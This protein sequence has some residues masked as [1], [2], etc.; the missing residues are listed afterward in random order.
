MSVITLRGQERHAAFVRAVEMLSEGRSH[1]W[2]MRGDQGPG[3]SVSPGDFTV[4][5][6]VVRHR[7][8]VC[9]TS[10]IWVLGIRSGQL[11]SRLMARRGAGQEELGGP[12]RRVRFPLRDATKRAGSTCNPSPRL[13]IL[14]WRG[15]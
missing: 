8:G 10:S 9:P 6:P 13:H 14:P 2:H 7:M 4:S 11:C 1:C 5:C 15:S 12:R 3:C